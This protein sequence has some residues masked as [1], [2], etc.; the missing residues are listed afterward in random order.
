MAMSKQ[1]WRGSNVTSCDMNKDLGIVLRASMKVGI[2]LRQLDE[3]ALKQHLAH[4]QTCGTRNPWSAGSPFNAD[5]HWRV[6]YTKSSKRSV[7][8]AGRLVMPR[9]IAERQEGY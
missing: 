7:S 5:G 4:L 8:S 1:G 3:G 6:V 9:K 2:V